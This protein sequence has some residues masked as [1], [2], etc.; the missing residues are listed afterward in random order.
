MRW[1]KFLLTPTTP[2]CGDNNTNSNN[3]K[4]LLLRRKFEKD[5]YLKIV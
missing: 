5:F 3:I 1:W 4:L 2:E